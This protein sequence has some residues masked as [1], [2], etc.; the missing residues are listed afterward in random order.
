MASVPMLENVKEFLRL[1]G[2]RDGATLAPTCHC[3]IMRTIIGA[4]SLEKGQH[5]D[6]YWQSTRYSA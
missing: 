4:H 3:S 6:R 1:G 2:L 5:A